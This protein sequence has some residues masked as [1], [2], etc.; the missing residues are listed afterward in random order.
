MS[1]KT[2][3][4][5]IDIGNSL[6]K[7]A[8]FEGEELRE[9]FTCESP[10]LEGHLNILQL[11]YPIQAMIVSST[12]REIPPV[13]RTLG[14][15]LKKY[16]EL[17]HETPIPVTID[18]STPVTLGRDRI[19]TSV[20]AHGLYPGENVLVV[21][22]GTCVTYDL[23]DQN[24]HFQGGNIAPGMFM[25]LKAMHS[26]TENLPFPPFRV[27]EHL[28]GRSTSEALQNGALKG[29][30]YEIESFINLLEAKYG[31]LKV[32][33]TGGDALYFADYFKS[34]IFVIQNLVLIGLNKILKHNA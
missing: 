26:F 3:H 17:D 15:K 12:R 30:I 14:N 20:A 1:Q 6:I 23:T 8:L 28:L 2:L 5:C 32:I 34:K 33:L 29:T 25:R 16:I 19:A 24:G 4:L 10:E 31:A 27:P 11:K 9:F 21:D 7:V 18:Y 22:A 13:L